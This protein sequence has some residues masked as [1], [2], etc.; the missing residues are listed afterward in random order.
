MAFIVK[1][2]TI[3]ESYDDDA[4][5]ASKTNRTVTVELEAT[6]G[7]ASDLLKGVG[8]DRCVYITVP[9]TTPAGI[10]RDIKTRIQHLR[11]WKTEEMALFNQLHNTTIEA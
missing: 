5:N 9:Y 3:S 6:M 2:V 11:D 10:V 8:N 7:A 1:D 4:T